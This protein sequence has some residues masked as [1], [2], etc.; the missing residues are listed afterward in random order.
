MA[1]NISMLRFVLALVAFIWYLT[2]LALAY[3]G[4]FEIFSKFCN[5]RKQR[6]NGVP[7][8]PQAGV[9]IIRPL[10][11]VEPEMSSCLESLFVQ[12]YPKDNF[13]ILFCVDDPN[14]ECIPIVQTLIAKYPDVDALI[15]IYEGYDP[16]KQYLDEHYGPNPKVNNLAKGFVAAKYDIV[17]VM[18]SNVWGNLQILRKSV[19]LLLG[20]LDNG[21]RMKPS[22]RRIALVHHTP[23]AM[24]IAD[25]EYSL[26][27]LNTGAS[28]M[29]SNKRVLKKFG[30]RLDEMFLLSS[31]AKFYVGFNKVSVAP[32]VNGKLN[33]YRK[34][35]IDHAVLLIPHRAHEL[36][37]FKSADVI[38]DAKYFSLLGPGHAIKFFLRYIGEDNMIGIC[39]W[40]NCHG[41]TG[42]TGDVVVQPLSGE[43]NSIKDYITRR[44]RWLRVRKYMVLAATLLEPLTELIVSGIYGNFGISNLFFDGSFKWWIFALHMLVWISTDIVQYRQLVL[45]TV[46]SAELDSQHKPWWLERR[47]LPALNRSFVNWFSA[48][49]GRE[50]LALPIWLGAMMGHEIDWRGRPFMLKKDLTAEEL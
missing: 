46:E 17:W 42:M 14:D 44:I 25:T 5:P 9:S 15:L 39:L 8:G 28:E 49:L 47:H 22:G 13:E 2:V 10:K 43:D 6:S 24:S 38:D 40:E 37:F 21:R 19:D 16:V 33:M 4:F 45:L 41:R 23:L 36:E 32:C 27:P 30:A 12:D 18:D 20:N 35:D 34:L 1:E 31:H 7:R 48:W 3:S 11:G 26:S 50:L 29:F